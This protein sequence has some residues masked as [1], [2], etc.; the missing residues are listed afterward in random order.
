MCRTGRFFLRALEDSRLKS[1][2]ELLGRCGS[3][4]EITSWKRKLHVG[5]QLK[6]GFV[7]KAGG[8]AY[9]IC[10]MVTEPSDIIQKQKDRTRIILVN[11]VKHPL[12]C[13]LSEEA[14]LN[15]ALTFKQIQYKSNTVLINEGDLTGNCYFIQMGT[16]IYEDKTLVGQN[17]FF[18]E[19]QL[20]RNIPSQHTITTKTDCIMLEI[21]RDEMV[22]AIGPVEG[23]NHYCSPLNAFKDNTLS[24]LQ[25]LFRVYYFYLENS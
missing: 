10:E 17:K 23:L 2:Y 22:S 11:L 9:Q 8:T 25:K 14:M 21:N 13:N 19:E 12:F 18:N 24:T 5:A 1:V 3:V 20:I 6:Q 16:V 7:F 15:F 4:G